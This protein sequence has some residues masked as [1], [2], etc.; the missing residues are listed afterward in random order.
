MPEPTQITELV[1]KSDEEKAK[2]IEDLQDKVEGDPD[3]PDLLEEF[4]RITNA[5]VEGESEPATEPAVEEPAV[6]DSEP[7]TQEDP[8]PAEPAAEPQQHTESWF[9]K[10]LIPRETYVDEDGVERPIWTF[11]DPKSGPERLAKSYVNSQKYIR[12]LEKQMLPNAFTEGYEKA[13]AEYEAKLKEAQQKAAQTPVQ[14]QIQQSSFSTQTAESS[15]ATQVVDD[16]QIKQLRADLD[17][18]SNT[19]SEDYDVTEHTKAIQKY[20]DAVRDY[21]RKMYEAKL[22]EVST[23]T[24]KQA[25]AQAEAAKKEQERRQAEA[26]R[27][28]QIEETNKAYQEAVKS[29]D[30]FAGDPDNK[31][32]ATGKSFTQLNTE[33]INFHQKLA[34]AMT[35]KYSV[36]DKEVS[37]AEIMFRRQ[38]PTVLKTMSETGLQT[39]RDYE[40]WDELNQIDAIRMGYVINP[41]TKTWEQKPNVRFPDMKSAA[42]YYYDQSGKKAEMERK[43]KVEAARQVTNAINKRDL[44]VV[45]MDESR[46]ANAMEGDQMTEEQALHELKE[47]EAYDMENVVYDYLQGKTE[48]LDRYNK[49]RAKLS[50]PLIDPSDIQK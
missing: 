36:T 4:N 14:P 6:P 37:D 35:G 44:G 8:A 49:A 11:D 18:A 32:Y 28:K 3:N 39:P 5:K 21:D 46:T 38:D 12:K 19:D 50:L 33:A 25:Q 24:E 47:I 42:L 31:Q 1:Y 2:A 29:I 41:L 16:T 13:K 27:Q 34:R 45:Q 15:T 23:K 48:M 20:N 22:A 7:T 26:D 17:K 40:K 30:A 9:P 10:D 43:S